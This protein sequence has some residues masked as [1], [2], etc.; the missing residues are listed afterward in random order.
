MDAAQV[1]E[2]SRLSFRSA[3]KRAELLGNKLA[4]ERRWLEADTAYH[5]AD[6]L[7][8]LSHATKNMRLE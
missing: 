1:R 7:L 2:V 6:V 3:A 8:A 4:K 5:L